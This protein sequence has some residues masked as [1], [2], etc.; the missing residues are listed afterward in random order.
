MVVLMFFNVWGWAKETTFLYDMEF[1]FD[2]FDRDCIA[3]TGTPTG[4]TGYGWELCCRFTF[5]AFPVTQSA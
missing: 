4:G 1:M 3:P 5:H 2:L